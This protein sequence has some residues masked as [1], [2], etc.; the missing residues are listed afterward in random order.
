M[1]APGPD[2]ITRPLRAP[3]LVLSDLLEHAKPTGETVLGPDERDH[4]LDE[5]RV[6]HRARAAVEFLERD[7]ERSRRAVR[8]AVGHRVECVGDPDDAR[9]ERDGIAGQAIGVAGA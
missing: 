5:L 4:L 9:L 7:L 2:T 3:A 8:P 1:P 6:E